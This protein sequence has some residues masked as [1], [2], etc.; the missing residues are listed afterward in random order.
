MDC[1]IRREYKKLIM[2]RERVR[3]LTVKEIAAAYGV[4]P[5]QAGSWINACASDCMR[6]AMR[7][8]QGDPDHPATVRFTVEEFTTDPRGAMIA[9]LEEKITKVETLFPNVKK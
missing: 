2:T 1:K 7:Q 3:G 5:R 6:D 4:T 9:I 8:T